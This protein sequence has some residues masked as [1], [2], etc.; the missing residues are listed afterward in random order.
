MSLKELRNSIRREFLEYKRRF[1][2]LTAR[3]EHLQSQ[4][5]EF[6]KYLE[7]IKKGAPFHR[8]KEIAGKLRVATPDPFISKL[9]L[10]VH[11]RESLKKINEELQ[12][13]GEE[14][15]SIERCLKEGIE[16]PLCNGTGYLTKSHIVRG[17]I[18][19]EVLESK[20]CPLCRGVGKLF[21]DQ[22]MHDDEMISKYP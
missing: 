5:N 11:I 19:Q 22:I 16:C 13:I 12:D 2:E 17:D 10:L 3:R 6:Q 7:E 15:A 9:V 18:I 1:E 14:L 8:I 21:Y 4:K 20:K